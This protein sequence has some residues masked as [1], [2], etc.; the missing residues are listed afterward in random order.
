MNK[1]AFT[2]FSTL[3]L[4][5]IFSILIIKIFEVKSI[6]SVNIANQYRYIQAKNHLAFLEEY[7]NSL[8]NLASLD[9]I[10]IKNPNYDIYSLIKKENNKYHIELIVEDLN[11]D[12]RV[13]KKIT[14]LAL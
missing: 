12:I 5:F 6:S 9:K 14:I 4:I 10:T 1:K 7:I 8:T 13:Y 2:L 3:I 11:F